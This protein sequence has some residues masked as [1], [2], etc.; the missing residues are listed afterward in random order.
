[1][2]TKEHARA[3]KMKGPLAESFAENYRRGAKNAEKIMPFAFSAFFAPLCF[4][5][6]HSWVA[7]RPRC[8]APSFFVAIALSLGACFG[9][10]QE[11]P[12]RLGFKQDSRPKLDEV[13]GSKL[14]L[15]GQAAMRQPNGASYEF[16]E[17]L[18]PP[19]R[20]VNADFHY[21][22]IVLS[23]PNAKVKARLIS[24]GSGINLRGGAR[25]WNDLGTP[26]IFR[27][28]PDEFRFGE[29]L[30]RLE[31][32]TLA[33][34]YLPIPE[35]RYAHA[36]EVYQLEAF[37]STDPALAEQGIVFAKFSL[38]SGTNG[39]ITVQVEASPLAFSEGAITDSNGHRVVYFY[40]D[41]I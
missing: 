22:P 31:H 10:A 13:L 33:E 8:V 6:T 19:P 9:A 26:V 28:G 18:L 4:F 37:A 3:P 14:D 36:T 35:I 1:M 7:V 23:A 39:L 30:S 17:S 24:N 41:W 27:V 11:L 5:P 12:A 16:F 25:S 20:Y 2:T 29:I 21:Y 40:E 32:P 15:W 34:G 38:A